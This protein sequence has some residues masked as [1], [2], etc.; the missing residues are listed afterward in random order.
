MTSLLFIQIILRKTERKIAIQKY[1][2]NNLTRFILPYQVPLLQMRHEIK[3][4]AIAP[5]WCFALDLKE[6][7]TV[8]MYII[9]FLNI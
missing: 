1:V 6:Y 4:Y 9:Q 5:L 7:L 2:S 8:L 3:I